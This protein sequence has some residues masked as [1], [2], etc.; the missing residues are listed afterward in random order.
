MKQKELV[1]EMYKACFT[2]DTKLQ[3]EIFMEE[4]RKVFSRKQR[5]KPFTTK[6]VVIR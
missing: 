2:H 3:K 4:L 1:K 5:G 6:W